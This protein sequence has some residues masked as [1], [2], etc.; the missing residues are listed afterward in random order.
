MTEPLLNYASASPFA[1]QPDVFARNGL[2]WA[3]NNASLPQCCMTCGAP[4]DTPPLALHFTWDESFRFSRA[5]TLKLRNAVTIHG[6]LCPARR[7]RHRRAKFLGLAGM[8]VA[9]FICA[10]A[11][12]A[13]VISESATVP[14]YTIPALWITFAAFALLIVFA[15]VLALGTR[16]I[17]CVRIEDG[18]G[19]FDDVSPDLLK[20][21]PQVA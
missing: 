16:T 18:Y 11:G 20:S 3:R 4:A 5:N 14:R 9:A 13:A 12:L 2:L 8:V 1:G 21:L 7:R 6:Y 17:T 10:A 15:F 19:A